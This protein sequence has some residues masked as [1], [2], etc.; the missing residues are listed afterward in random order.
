MSLLIFSH[1]DYYYL[2]NIIEDYI[3]DLQE[4]NPIFICNSNSNLEKP[5][6]FKKYIEYND[7]LCYAQRWINILKNENILTEYILVVHD[8]NIIADCYVN[9]IKQLFNICNENNIDRCSLNVFNGTSIINSDIPLCK[10][11]SHIKRKTYV[12]YDLCPAI[13]KKSEFLNLWLNFPNETYQKSELNN[14]LQ[15]YCNKLKCYGLQKTNNKIYYCIG[16]PYYDFFKILHITIK[17][18]LLNPVEVYMDLLPYFIKITNKY[19][20]TNKIKINNS[21]GFILINLTYI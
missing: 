14:N 21:Y 18:E 4:L 7:N 15:M 3:A 6:G 17:G 8:V 16:R 19:N 11:E 2:W 9:K 12:P 5:K 1:S 20:L 13:W 10:L